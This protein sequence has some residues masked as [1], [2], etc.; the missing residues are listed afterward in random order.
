MP[1][2]CVQGIIGES[3]AAAVAGTPVTAAADDFKFHGEE[4]DYKM[5][6]YFA[7]TH[8]HNRFGLALSLSP[9]RRLIERTSV[10]FP[11]RFSAG[12]AAARTTFFTTVMA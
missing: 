3:Y 9:R 12:G 11:L 5:D 4:A 1:G 2:R 10:A 6:S 8:K 7:T